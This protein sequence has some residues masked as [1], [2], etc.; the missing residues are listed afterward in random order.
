LE[1]QGKGFL[2]ESLSISLKSIGAWLKTRM[3]P[4]SVPANRAEEGLFMEEEEEEETEE[5]SEE[6]EIEEE[7]E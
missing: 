3:S 4:F 7:E 6:E 2:V 5:G 1:W